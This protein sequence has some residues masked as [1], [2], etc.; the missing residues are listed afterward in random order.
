M[1]EWTLSATK[2]GTM[3]HVEG[4]RDFDEEGR[5]REAVALVE[6]A[7]GHPQIAGLAEDE[8]MDKLKAEAKAELERQFATPPED[9]KLSI[10]GDK[11][12]I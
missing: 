5:P 4:Q 8:L 3:Y 10:D 7:E 12:R 2:I 11:V 1:T 6:Y 9:E